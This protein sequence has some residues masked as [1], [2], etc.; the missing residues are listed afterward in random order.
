M[1]TSVDQFANHNPGCFRG[2][3][4]AANLGTLKLGVIPSFRNR[5]D[6][7]GCLPMKFG[8]HVQHVMVEQEV[9]CVGWDDRTR[10]IQQVAR[11]EGLGYMRVSMDLR[12]DYLIVAQ[13]GLI[14][15]SP[16]PV[17]EAMKEAYQ[18]C[19]EF[20]VKRLSFNNLW[21][22]PERDARYHTFPTYKEDKEVVNQAIKVAGFANGKIVGCDVYEAE[23]RIRQA[24]ETEVGWGF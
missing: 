22:P 16:K 1:L 7:D 4:V 21:K 23:D 13:P 12:R 14:S 11:R 15:A 5:W 9:A 18:S 10:M 8:D 6:C 19:V 2:W 20:A 3:V 17:R 24:L